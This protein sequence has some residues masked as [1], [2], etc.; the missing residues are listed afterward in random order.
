LDQQTTVLELR[1]IVRAFCD[2]RDW[3]QFHGAKDLAIGVSTEAAELLEHF[4]FRSDAE[5]ETLLREPDGRQEIEHELVDVLFFVLRFADRYGIDL[6]D[7][8]RRKM[9]RNAQRYPVDKSKGSNR[10]YS[11]L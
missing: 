4:R 7:A 2:E 8:F 9:S 3:E 11:E 6:D 1:Q 10:K 5:C